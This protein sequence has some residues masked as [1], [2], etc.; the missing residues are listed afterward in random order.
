MPEILSINPSDPSRLNISKNISLIGYDCISG[1]IT[2][3]KN[4]VDDQ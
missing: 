3:N 1:K 2:E 4:S